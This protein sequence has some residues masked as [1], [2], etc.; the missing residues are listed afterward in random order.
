MEPEDVKRFEAQIETTVQ[1]LFL[2]S[3]PA[4]VKE[5]TRDRLRDALTSELFFCGLY[6]YG[7]TEAESV[8]TRYL[9]RR[10]D[11]WM[12]ALSLKTA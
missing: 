11:D 5:L 6:R 2:D 9:D 7:D 10:L 12:Q 1:Q 3:D 4:S 8:L